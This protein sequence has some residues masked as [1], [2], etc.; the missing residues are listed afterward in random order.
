MSR[1]VAASPSASYLGQ[2]PVVGAN[3]VQLVHH[4]VDVVDLDEHHVP[5]ALQVVPRRRERVV[6]R[7]L[8][9]TSQVERVSHDVTVMTSHQSYVYVLWLR[10]G[11]CGGS[12]SH[13]VREV[14]ESVVR[15]VAESCGVGGG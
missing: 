1:P 9:V 7:R 2:L 8:L 12:V 15:E 3:G 6:Q 11:R 5:E 13:V 14:A 10:F 4:G